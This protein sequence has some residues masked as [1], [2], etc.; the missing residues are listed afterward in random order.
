MSISFASPASGGEGPSAAD[1]NGH[2][3]VVE[4]LSYE[5]SIKTVHGDKDAVRVRLHDITDQQTYEDVLWFGGYLVGSLKGRIG[6]KV[7]ALMGQ[8]AAKAGQ[9]PPWQLQD[10]S[11]NPQ[12]VQAAT[13]YLTGQ[14]A[15]TLAA[16][17]AQTAVIAPVAAAPSAL[18][19]A[20]GNLAGI[21]K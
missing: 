12:A 8:G 17:V 11:T 19:A 18:D 4:P 5:P 15:A 20:L 14:V 2:V 10:L 21:V 16:P 3:L 9:S 1:V 6:D 7:L 13:A